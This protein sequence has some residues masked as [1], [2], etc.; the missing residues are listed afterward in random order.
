[1]VLTKN[2]QEPGSSW[3][4]GYIFSLSLSLSLPFFTSLSVYEFLS[5]L[6]YIRLHL[7]IHGETYICIGFN[8]SYSQCTLNVKSGSRPTWSQIVVIDIN[9]ARK[10]D[11][12]YP[13]LN[14]PEYGQL[15]YTHL[16]DAS[17]SVQIATPVQV[18][19]VLALIRDK[20]WWRVHLITT[21]SSERLKKQ[22]DK[23]MSHSYN[24]LRYLHMHVP[25]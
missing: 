9:V 10:Y 2:G 23:T 16:H 15:N 5:D 4:D 3:L 25:K 14:V 18:Y 19:S 11:W 13:T 12:A 1:M 21:V 24:K 20:F 17:L 22:V 6:G 8:G 7:R